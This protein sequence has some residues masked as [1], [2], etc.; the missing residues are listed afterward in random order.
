MLLSDAIRRGS[1]AYEG[2]RRPM[3]KARVLELLA[4]PATRRP[5]INFYEAMMD[6]QSPDVMKGGFREAYDALPDEVKVAIAHPRRGLNSL[7]RGD[8][9]QR[10]EPAMSWTRS[11]SWAGW[12]GDYV[13][14]FTDLASFDAAIDTARVAALARGIDALEEYGVGDDEDEVIVL[15]ARWKRKMSRQQMDQQRWKHRSR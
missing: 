3:T 14:P 5:I 8:I 13:F 15:G 6:Y 4:N 2:P 1:R 7:W 12:F 9:K 11:R 10:E